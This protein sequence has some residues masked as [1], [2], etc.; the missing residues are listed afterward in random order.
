MSSL[1]FSTLEPQKIPKSIIPFS[2][3]F[4]CQSEILEHLQ[5]R[6]RC[7]E[8]WVFLYIRYEMTF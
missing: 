2:L 6:R 8:A 3:Y 4:D 1:P 7:A 5:A